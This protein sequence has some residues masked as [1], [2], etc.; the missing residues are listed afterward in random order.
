[1]KQLRQKIVSLKFGTTLVVLGAFLLVM[2]PQEAK[3]IA[4]IGDVVIDPTNLIQSTYTALNTALQAALVPITSMINNAAADQRAQDAH[5]GAVGIAQGTVAAKIVVDHTFASAVPGS[6]GA[7]GAPG[8][9]FCRRIMEAQNTPAV[10]DAVTTIKTALQRAL[11]LSGSG[12]DHSLS[13]LQMMGQLCQMGFLPQGEDCQ[14]SSAPSGYNDLSVFSP[15]VVVDNLSMQWP[16]P[17]TADSKTGRLAIDTSATPQAADMPALAAIYHCAIMHPDTGAVT[18][19]SSSGT[20]GTPQAIEIHFRKYKESGNANIPDDTCL[21]EVAKRLVIPQNAPTA[22][23][24]KV[25]Q[26]NATLCQQMQSKMSQT[27]YNNCI[28]STGVSYMTIMRAKACGV[29]NAQSTVDKAGNVMNIGELDRSV[30]TGV[31]S[32]DAYVQD[33]D[34]QKREFPG[35]VRRPGEVKKFES[36]K[37]Y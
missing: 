14:N 27:D 24:A 15:G 1:M 33:L 36:D 13:A 7:P 6:N 19:A 32:C 16:T 37:A 35:A 11:F 20:I 23:L 29:G 25:W 4:G 26:A 12:T 34:R 31:A 8:T 21:G 28:G 9:S 10:Y 3:A 22:E 2:Q 17:L 30:E 18:T 5:N